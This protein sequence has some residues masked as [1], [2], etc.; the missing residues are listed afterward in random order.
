[1]IKFEWHA[2][3]GL[4]IPNRV[5]LVNDQIYASVEFAIAPANWRSLS[6]CPDE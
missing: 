6:Y 3:G 2:V 5:G 4:E 1:M